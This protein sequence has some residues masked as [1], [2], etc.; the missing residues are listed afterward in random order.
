MINYFVCVIVF[1]LRARQVVITSMR[2]FK[3]ETSHAQ[4]YR[5]NDRHK[6]K[7]FKTIFY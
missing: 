3:N 1:L 5:R 4:T 7:L 2:K 6:L